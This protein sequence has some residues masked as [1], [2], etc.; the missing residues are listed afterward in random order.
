V[1]EE[2]RMLRTLSPEARAL[3]EE[4]D[5]AAHVEAAMDEPFSAELIFE[6]LE[7]IAALED[8]RDR[9][10]VLRIIKARSEA[11]YRA[12]GELLLGGEG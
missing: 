5:A 7:R 9:A 11:A 4:I 10:L 3:A 8:P 1:D 2:M 12:A 6:H